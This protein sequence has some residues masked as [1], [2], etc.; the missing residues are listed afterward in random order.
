MRVA[1]AMRAKP[2]KREFFIY[3]IQYKLY[4]SPAGLYSRPS[5]STH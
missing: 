5:R 4:A 2:V 1:E 3:S